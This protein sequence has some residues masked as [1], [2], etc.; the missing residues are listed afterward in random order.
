MGT[1]RRRP[2]THHVASAGST[3]SVFVASVERSLESSIRERRSQGANSVSN[4]AQAVHPIGHPITHSPKRGFKSRVSAEHT[5]PGRK[6]IRTGREQGDRVGLGSIP[7]AASRCH[8]AIQVWATR[9]R[10]RVLYL[11]GGL[12]KSRRPSSAIVSGQLPFMEA[13]GVGQYEQPVPFM[14]RA[15][16]KRRTESRRNAVA[17]APKVSDDKVAA[18]A[19]VSGD[20]FEEDPRRSRF[21]NDPGDMGPEVAWVAGTAPLA[22][23]TEGLAGV[24]CRYNLDLSCP[25]PTVEGCDVVPDGTVGQGSITLAV[26]EHAGRMGIPLDIADGAVL[27]FG[28]AEAKFEASDASTQ[29]ESR[30]GRWWRHIV[31]P[32]PALRGARAGGSVVATGV[33]SRP[34]GCECAHSGGI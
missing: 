19:E 14:A 25:G 6:V 11:L 24:S 18:E 22:A 3:S 16:F 31:F 1:Q 30:K 4:G 26:L 21:S 12:R 7:R 33:E 17:H 10:L 8:S 32:R 27:W 13:V 15:R 2:A 29:S 20:V 28:D 9:R 34:S 5:V 23:P